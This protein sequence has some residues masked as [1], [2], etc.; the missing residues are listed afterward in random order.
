MV[1]KNFQVYITSSLWPNNQWLF[2]VPKKGSRW[3]IIP[4]LA[5]Y[6]TYTPL[7]YCLLGGGLYLRPT[8]FYWTKFFSEVIHFW[9]IF[10]WTYHSWFPDTKDI[11]LLLLEK[12]ILHQL[13]SGLSHYLRGSIDFQVVVWYFRT[14]NSITMPF[15]SPTNSTLSFVSVVQHKLGAIELD[16]QVGSISITTT[17]VILFRMGE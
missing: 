1:A 12:E 15:V 10:D 3:H 4:Q 14:I 5:V 8:T 9:H 2:L 16:V 6:T 7:V 13:I 11:Q 17:E